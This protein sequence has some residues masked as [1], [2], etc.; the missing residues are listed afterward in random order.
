MAGFKLI[1]ENLLND[2]GVIQEVNCSDYY[3]I[4]P[5]FIA[6]FQE[7]KLFIDNAD[8]LIVLD[9]VILNKKELIHKYKIDSWY[10]V[11]LS[12]YLEMGNEF[13]QHLRG[14]FSGVLLDKKKNK[15]IIFTDHLGTKFLYYAKSK[16]AL[17][18]SSN[19]KDIYDY[20]KSNNIGYNLSVE[21]AYLLLTYG[22]MIENRTLCEEILK[23]QPG[24]Y[25]IIEDGNLKEQN[26]WMLD[27]SPEMGLS[28]NDAIEL[29]DSAFDKAVSLQFSKDLEHQYKHIVALSGGL[30]SRMVTFA[31]DKL[32]YKDQL[33][34]TFSHGGYLDETIAK[35]IAAALKHEWIFK[36]LSDGQWLREVDEVNLQTGG[37]VIYAGLAHG[38][39]LYKFLNFDKLGLIHSGQL[40]D[41]VIGSFLSNDNQ[42]GSKFNFVEGRGAYSRGLLGRLHDLKFMNTYDNLEQAIF[43]SRGLAG[44]NNG[45]AITYNFSE[46]Y[47]PFFDI[48]FLTSVMKIP[49]SL[50]IGHNIYKKWIVQKY[51][52]ADHY[53][54]EKTKMKV[55]NPLYE[56]LKFNFKGKD[57]SIFQLPELIQRH[58]FNISSNKNMNPIGYYLSRNNDLRE[59]LDGFYQYVELIEDKQLREDVLHIRNNG[60]PLEKLQA[61]TLLSAL[62]LFFS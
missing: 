52:A 8:Y 32:G 60:N 2:R 29:I 35:Q 20:Y 47:S 50:R 46:T 4:A 25:L 39:S 12:M 41:V 53:I 5:N 13:F 21:N 16:N 7:D 28:E 17:I 48:D 59:Y 14:S 38:L 36:S 55:S 37:N 15:W 26:F 6:K 11:L 3:H 51:P 40:G 23:V 58:L 42:W 9:G 18:C 44:A 56:K 43:Y 45:L 30:D 27:N 61:V 34:F 62:K 24:C 10:E 33:N 22:F 49:V 1:I 19:I 31:A 57:I 54:W